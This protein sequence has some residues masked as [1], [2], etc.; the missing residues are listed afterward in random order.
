MNKYVLIFEMPAFIPTPLQGDQGTPIFCQDEDLSYTLSGIATFRNF[1]S[2]LLPG[3]YTRMDQNNLD[4][5]QDCMDEDQDLC[6]KE[7][8][9]ASS[10]IR[11]YTEE[12][13]SGVESSGEFG[14]SSF[15]GETDVQLDDEGTSSSGKSLVG[16]VLAERSDHWE[17]QDHLRKR[18]TATV[19]YE[20][21]WDSSSDGWTKHEPASSHELLDTQM[22]VDISGTETSSDSNTNEQ[23][24]RDDV[25]EDQNGFS[26][27]DIS[28]D[29]ANLLETS[30][31]EV[32]GDIYDELEGKSSGTNPDDSNFEIDKED[33]SGQDLEL[34]INEEP[35]D[36]SGEEYDQES[37]DF[38]PADSRRS[39]FDT[40][41]DSWKPTNGLNF[42]SLSRVVG[43]HEA[44][45]HGRP[46]IVIY[47]K[48]YNVVKVVLK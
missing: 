37:G 13:S 27:E 23:E 6:P 21:F 8:L 44:N 10:R 22:T 17:S 42:D 3:L 1:S 9:T 29:L 2:D 16:I 41:E 35:F 19:D 39:H 25:Y 45:P 46:E 7:T 38:E 24:E 12:L 26:S 4:F 47:S 48:S 5:V 40:D 14:I 18:D 32:S 30:S 20:D 43:G 11:Q 36:G 33:E 34:S 15:S 28:A 31:T